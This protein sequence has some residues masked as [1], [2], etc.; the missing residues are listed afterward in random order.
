MNI[1][2]QLRTQYAQLAQSGAVA[3]AQVQIVEGG[4]T[5]TLCLSGVQPLACE[6]HSIEV[7]GPRYAQADADELSRLGQQLADHLRYL[8][9]PLQVHEVDRELDVVQLRSY[10]PRRDQ[11]TVRYFEAT[12]ARGGVM[13]AR[14]EKKPQASREQI[15]AVVTTEVLELLCDDLARLSA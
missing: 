15:P 10:P 14:Y 5:L 4:V 6:L 13:L 8:L 12:L 1:A 11:Q 7:N 3:P 2:H 9:E